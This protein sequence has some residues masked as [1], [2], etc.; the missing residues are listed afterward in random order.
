MFDLR[1]WLRRERAAANREAFASVTDQLWL[2]IGGNGRA[3]APKAI[4]DELLARQRA[5]YEAKVRDEAGEG[6]AVHG[7]GL[8]RGPV[9]GV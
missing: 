7:A 6:G 3:R 1:E 8:L 5:L 4:I 9:D 2:A